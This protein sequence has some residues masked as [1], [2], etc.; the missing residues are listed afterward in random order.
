MEYPVDYKCETLRIQKFDKDHDHDVEYTYINAF[1]RSLAPITVSYDQSRLLELSVTFTYD[2]HFF[3]GLDRL[4]R[5]YR[6]GQIRKY[7]DPFQFVNTK[8]TITPK[9]LRQQ[10]LI[11]VQMVLILSIPSIINKN[12]YDPKLRLRL[13][14]ILTPIT[15]RLHGD[16][17][18]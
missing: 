18:K 14:K 13:E 2:R 17:N 3:G 16:S 8:P 12:Y 7:N 1:P 5:A 4:S 10:I 9:T 11:M 15:I 6:S